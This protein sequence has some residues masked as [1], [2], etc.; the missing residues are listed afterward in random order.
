MA[1]LGQALAQQLARQALAETAQATQ[2]VQLANRAMTWARE[3]VRGLSPVELEGD[4]FILALQDLA[5]QAEHLFGITCRVTCDCL[6]PMP[7]HTVATHLYRIAQEA[8]SNAVKHGQARNVVLALTT[9]QDSTTLTMHDDGIGFQAYAH[10]PT[11]MGLRI[12]HYRASMIGASLAIHSDASS[13]TTVICEWPHPET[14]GDDGERQPW[15]DGASTA[16]A[17]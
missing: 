17:R 13:G 12:M 7:N 5:A 8:V 15:R 4:G 9:G 6:P 3:L 10:K 16:P 2:L 14:T 11:G 1:F